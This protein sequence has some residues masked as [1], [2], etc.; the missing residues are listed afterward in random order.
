VNW[1][2]A[3]RY[4]NANGVT[5]MNI[6]RLLLGKA[7]ARLVLG[8]A[9]LVPICAAAQD[10]RISTRLALVESNPRFY[11]ANLAFSVG[12]CPSV[13]DRVPGLVA[14]FV[15]GVEVSRSGF[16]RTFGRR[17]TGGVQTAHAEF[18][19]ELP[20]GTHEL[21]AR[22][23]GN[24]TLAPSASSSLSIGIAAP[25]SLA[26]PDGG[27]VIQAGLYGGPYFCFSGTMDARPASSSPA[28]LPA[29][30]LRFP[31]GTLAVRTGECGPSIDMMQPFSEA[32][33]KTLVVE[34]PEEIPSG[35]QVWILE[36]SRDR[37]AAQWKIAPDGVVQGRRIQVTIHS[38]PDTHVLNT[39][40]NERYLEATLGWAMPVASAAGL[41]VQGLWWGGTA[42]NGWGLDISQSGDNLF[43]VLFTYDGDGRPAWYVMPSGR[44]DASHS[45]FTGAL[46]RPTGSPRSAYDASRFQAGASV[47]DATL[48]FNGA[49]AGT[50]QYSIFGASG[51]KPV[52]KL[53]FG[54][55]NAPT[56]NLS[57]LWWGG[58]SQA[59]WGVTMVEQ[60]GFL[61]AA[62][63]TY[64]ASGGVTW[65]FAPAMVRNSNGSY[66]GGLFRTTGA[67]WAGTSYDASRLKVMPAGSVT[68][69]PAG[70]GATLAFTIDGVA[71]SE[72]LVRYP[73]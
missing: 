29:D 17:C 47:G 25:F 57:G 9:S 6:S 30:T 71:G 19:T 69:T 61:F 68:V 59:G 15:D 42:E 36:S 62:W 5:G 44:W 14:F 51:V 58:P 72:S 46:Y 49:T 35:A 48:S 67:A 33:Y 31:H 41:D 40:P 34:Y 73:F 50:L 12:P 11:E 65:L 20:F 24:D 32:I 37:A 23:T 64:D 54:I 66:T 16:F 52:T 53:A 63:Y 60:G 38:T 8:A 26:D 2:F 21:V 27:G 4:H 39:Q 28:P 55:P 1:H 7:F 45:N 22:F 13:L 3:T 70:S 43:A 10:T 56:S 18:L